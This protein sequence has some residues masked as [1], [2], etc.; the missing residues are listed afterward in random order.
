RERRSHPES[1]IGRVAYGDGG[2]GLGGRVAIKD[3]SAPDLNL[4]AGWQRVDRGRGRHLGVAPSVHYQSRSPTRPRA[5]ENGPGATMAIAGGR[6]AREGGYRS[7]EAGTAIRQD[8]DAA[9]ATTSRGV[10]SRG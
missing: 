8:G 1:G 10:P 5:G 2:K 9:A 3:R 6:C 7:G 4:G